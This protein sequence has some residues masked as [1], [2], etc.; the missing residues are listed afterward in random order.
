MRFA[1]FAMAY[2]CLWSPVL[3]QVKGEVPN[4]F[5][6][7][8]DTEHYVF[9]WNEGDVSIEEI[10]QA[11]AYTELTFLKLGGLLGIDNMPKGRIIVTFNG[12]GVDPITYKKSLSHVDYQGRVH[13]YRYEPKG[14][15]GPFLHELIHSVRKNTLPKWDRFWEEGFASAIS[16]YLE[17]ETEEFSRFGYPMEVI[18]GYWLDVG[19]AIPMR[20][21]KT[22]HN[23]LLGCRLQSYVLREDFF[24]YLINEYG[25]EKYLKYAYSSDI[26]SFDLYSTIWGI[27]F[28]G[29]VKGWETDLNNRYKD[30][31]G[32]KDL[33]EEYLTKTPAKYLKVCEPEVDY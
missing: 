33:A 32:A 10:N 6:E 30:F 19:K 22:Q 9:L 13:L 29:L 3:S 25:I 27:T 31:K 26:G 20:Q 14:Y 7:R 5:Q 21:M 16:Y 24:T 2:L 23:Q 1:L 18:A 28:D 11:K 12:D 8:V 15:L 4:E 17:P